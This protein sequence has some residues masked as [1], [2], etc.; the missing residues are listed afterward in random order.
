MSENLSSSAIVISSEEEINNENLIQK[1][2]KSYQPA[3]DENATPPPEDQSSSC[4]PLSVDPVTIICS[5]VARALE[6]T[7]QTTTP[8][9]ETPIEPN[10]DEQEPR[11][12]TNARDINPSAILSV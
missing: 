7:E 5:A 6:P 9:I 12:T 4:N 2:W 3:V 11:D 10:E 1:Q 8:T